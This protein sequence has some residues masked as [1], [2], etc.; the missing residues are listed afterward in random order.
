MEILSF[1]LKSPQ[2]LACEQALRGALAAGQE[3]GREFATTSVEFEFRL[4]FPISISQRLFRCR[5]SN[6]RD[7]VASS[8]SFSR[9]AAR[10]PRRA[11]SQATQRQRYWTIANYRYI[12]SFIFAEEKVPDRPERPPTAPKPAP[13]V[14]RR[15][16]DPPEEPANEINY[17]NVYQALWNCDAADKDELP[18]RRGDLIYIYEKPHADWWIGSLFKPQGYSVG[19]VPKDYVMEAYEF[20]AA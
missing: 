14:P 19:L 17:A 4:Q 16:D 9:P 18:F 20:S 2:R 10:A 12:I 1:R 11:C 7:V 5:Y 13:P 8:P 15:S 3:K 6:S